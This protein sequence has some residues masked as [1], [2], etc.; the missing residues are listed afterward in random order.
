MALLLPVEVGGVTVSRASLHNRE[1]LE[2][3]DVRQGDLVRVQRA[4]DVIPQVV[5]RVEEEGRERGTPFQMPSTCPACGTEV[6]LR[7]PF[8]VCP[9][10][11]G[12]PAQLKARIVHFASRGGLDI[13]GLG[14]ETA[15][16]LVDRGLVPD[17]AS[18]FDLEAEELIGLPGFAEKSASNLVAAIAQRRKVDLHRFLF[19]LGIPEVGQ[20]VARDLALHFRTLEEIRAA[21][22]ERL[23]AVNGIGPKMSEAIFAF[24]E[25]GRNAR[26]ID[27]ILSRGVNLISPEAPADTGGTGRKVVFTGRSG[28]PRSELK[29]RA[30][31]AGFRVVSSV[32]AETDYVV[33]GSEA[34]SKLA[35]ARDLGVR[36]LNEEE[37]LNL[38]VEAGAE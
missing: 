24:L 21:D 20:A 13:E 1:E 36:I 29:K 16:L 23:E 34:G 32:S 19:G 6:F 18:L 31:A 4:G 17:L 25:E 30:E 10:R 35:K 7:G 15:A 12:C 33:A 27:A 5:E 11:F 38:L 8:S 9:N 3:K 26:V 22:R 14:E 37:F 28:L 2:R